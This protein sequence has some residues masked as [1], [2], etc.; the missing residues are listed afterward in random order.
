MNQTIVTGNSTHETVVTF[1]SHNGVICRPFKEVVKKVA[2]GSSLA[3]GQHKK[4]TLVGL[5]VVVAF[6]SVNELDPDLK[7][8]DVVF[9]KGD[10]VTQEW[11]KA[12]MTSEEV[13]GEF[14]VVPFNEVVFVKETE[15]KQ[16]WYIL[17]QPA[18]SDFRD[19]PLGQPF[20]PRN[21]PV[22]PL[23]VGDGVAPLVFDPDTLKFDPEKK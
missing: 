9:V 13:E 2:S 20:V 15:V 10:R 3:L 22:A 18:S 5:E 23:T 6:E 7:V 17:Q 4:T 11:A 1:T 19:L 14:I 21:E 12:I 16:N 8:G